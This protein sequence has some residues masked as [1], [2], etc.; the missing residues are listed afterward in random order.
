MTRPARGQVPDG[1]PARKAAGPAAY[2]TLLDAADQPG[3]GTAGPWL[4][5]RDRT[6]N[7]T[8]Q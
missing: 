1:Q 7:R 8:Q 3:A 4:L 2:A 5:L 6:A